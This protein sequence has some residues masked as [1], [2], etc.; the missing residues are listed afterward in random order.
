MKNVILFY[1]K[2]H[3]RLF[4]QPNT[5][6]IRHGL[7]KAETYGGWWIPGK[8]DILF[9]HIQEDKDRQLTPSPQK[10]LDALKAGFGAVLARRHF[11]EVQRRAWWVTWAAEKLHEYPQD[12]TQ[13]NSESLQLGGGEGSSLHN[14]DDYNWPKSWV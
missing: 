12:N 3:N 2:K 6:S 7:K 9:S 4:G 11:W 13:E 14:K 1:G 5:Y 10:C 8:M